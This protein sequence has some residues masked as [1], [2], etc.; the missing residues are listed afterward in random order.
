[1][2][3]GGGGGGALELRG[4]EGAAVRRRGLA[5]DIQHPF[6]LGPGE[7]FLDGGSHTGAH[8]VLEAVGS[9]E[10]LGDV[11]VHLDA[12]RAR[13]PRQYARVHSCVEDLL[14]GRAGPGLL[15]IH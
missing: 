14:N 5:L 6:E 12:A 15:S 1:M 8:F 11:L 4:A 9:L 13:H 3:D 7:L 2:G 10:A